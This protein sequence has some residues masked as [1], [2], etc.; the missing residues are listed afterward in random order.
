VLGVSPT[1][2]CS[3][4]RQAFKE[5]ARR[6]HPDRVGPARLHFFQEILDAYHVLA[7]PQRRSHYDRG[8]Y[9]AG[10]TAAGNAMST[11]EGAG[12][13][14]LP[15]PAPVLRTLFIKDA[16]FEAALARVSGS[17]TTGEAASAKEFAEGVTATIVLF[18]EEVARGGLLFLG[19][20]SCTPCDRCGGSGREGLFP[21]SVCDGEGLLEEKEI[22]R[23][24]VPPDVPDGTVMEMPLRGLG[25]HN[26]YLRL[27]IRI[28]TEK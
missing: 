3:A 25:V 16:P 21:C 9:H 5:L 2:T 10:I 15:Q 7:D 6:Y 20:P 26:F 8:L 28:G 13:R 14:D 19:V 27:H 17:L 24:Y 11:F 23:I 22:V 18:P 1:E 12:A 4:I